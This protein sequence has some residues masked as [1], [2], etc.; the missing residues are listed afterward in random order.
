MLHHLRAMYSS[1]SPLRATPADHFVA[2]IGMIGDYY[3]QYVA[4]FKRWSDF[5]EQCMNSIM[6]N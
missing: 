1:E 5:Q 6:A 2:S 4:W 3:E